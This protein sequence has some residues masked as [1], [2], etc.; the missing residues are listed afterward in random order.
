MSDFDL[1]VV[2]A[3]ISG[4]SLGHFAT[5]QGR[6]VLVLDKAAAPGGCVH[7]DRGG[8]LW[9]EL[10][11]HTLYNSYVNLIGLLETCGLRDR[12]LPRRKLRFYLLVD[13]RPRSIPSQLRF[14]ELLRGSPRLLF[15]PR[16]GQTIGNYY[17]RIVGPT[18]YRRVFKALFDA[19]ACQ[20]TTDFG[21]EYLFK[22]RPGRRKD[23]PRS[24]TLE[25][26]IGTLIEALAR[27]P[28]LEVRAG[29]GVAGVSREG[30]QYQVR[31]ADGTTY[32]APVLAIATPPPD[33][34]ELLA[35]CFPDIAELLST[36]RINRLYSLGVTVE[37]GAVSLPEL[38]GIVSPG[39]LF[40]SVVSRDVV[41]HP[42]CRGFTF[43]FREGDR[44][45][46]L[47]R[48]Q[49]V[50]GVDESRFQRI[51]H[52]INEIPTLGPGHA[53]LVRRIDSLAAGRNLLLCGNYFLGLSLEDCV[54]RAASEG[55][56]LMKMC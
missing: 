11:S 31:L 55:S 5:R 29:E 3:G 22:K 46:N 27:T 15:T 41:P 54:A 8:D 18:N 4:L 35:G 52:K 21:V 13:G 47:R 12:I 10:G 36:I 33:A 34:G 48:V 51:V 44:P 49:E 38:A 43:H 26:G 1:I 32:L 7:T 20:D 30:A 50:L 24:F 53:E 25:G 2:G 40:Y 14:L 23:F 56:K 19:V 42:G 17:A 6:K 39:D 16:A 9:L 37:R 28:G 45:A